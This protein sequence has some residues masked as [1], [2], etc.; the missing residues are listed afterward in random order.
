MNEEKAKEVGICSLTIVKI[1]RKGNG[2]NVVI[3]KL[4]FLFTE[5]EPI[6]LVARCQGRGDRYVAADDQSL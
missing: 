3:L 4:I 5:D 6:L 2:R 1:K